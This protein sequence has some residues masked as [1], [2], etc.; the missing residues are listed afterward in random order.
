MRLYRLTHVYHIYYIHVII[1]AYMYTYPRAHIPH[2]LLLRIH[3]GGR[4]DGADIQGGRSVTIH[5]YVTHRL[6]YT[7]LTL[8]LTLILALTLISTHTHIHSHPHTLSVSFGGKITQS[9][10]HTEMISVASHII[11]HMERSG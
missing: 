5:S 10:T 4:G 9:C 3:T 7:C 6:I 8:I 2:S 11:A 1:D